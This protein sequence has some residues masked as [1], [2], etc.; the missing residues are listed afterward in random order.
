MTRFIVAWDG[1]NELLLPESD[2][3]TNAAPE[4]A[5]TDDAVL[6]GQP[7]YLKFGGH[8]GL[9]IASEVASSIVCGLV[10]TDTLP[11]FAA[12]Y[13]RT[14]AIARDDWTL[15]CGQPTLEP[16]SLYFLS[17]LDLGRLTTTPPG[18]GFSA[19][20]GQAVTSLKMAIAIN[21]PFRI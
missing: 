20:V 13:L 12:P 7:V 14:G 5:E 11:T 16:G 10:T 8:L 1:Q 4:L 9:A 21:P 17:N 3:T 6:V 19:P 15:I 18:S 2:L